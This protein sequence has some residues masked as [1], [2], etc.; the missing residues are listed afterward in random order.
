[1]PGPARYIDTATTAL[2]TGRSVVLCLPRHVPPLVSSLRKSLEDDFGS[3][4]SSL[5]LDEETSASSPVDLLFE[6]FV[7][8]EEAGALRSAAS[9][10]ASPE[11]EGRIICVEGI[12]PSAWPSWRRFLSEFEQATRAIP[13]L[14][15]TLFLVILEGSVALSP[16]GEDVCLAV[17]RY[18]D[19][20]RFVDAHF[21]ASLVVE[22]R[23]FTPLQSRVAASVVA[24]LALWDPVL[25]DA[26]SSKS[27]DE[28]MEPWSTLESLADSRGWS[29][30]DGADPTAGWCE[31]IHASVEGVSKL[32]SAFLA[33]RGERRLVERRMWSGQVGVLFPFVEERRQILVEELGPLLRPEQVGEE[34][35]DLHALEIGQ[36]EHRILRHRQVVGDGT[37]RLVS[38]LKRVRNHLSHLQFVPS[39]LVGA[40]EFLM[41]DSRGGHTP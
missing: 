18:D 12:G 14:Q 4:W 32:H 38:K 17:L 15:R 37:M 10:A 2:R 9:L 29:T 24:A 22:R 27:L 8:G 21:Y 40:P 6:Q 3:C 25:A 23:D 19:V 13:A 39:G 26:L 41:T 28:I 33:A 35:I 36:L 30:T 11:F 34:E 16:P 31:G 1:M 5:Y 20:V 7:P